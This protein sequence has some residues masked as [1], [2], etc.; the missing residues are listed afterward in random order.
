MRWMQFFTPV[1]S[2][3]ADEARRYIEAGSP[4]D[5][6]I[7]DVRQHVEYQAGH[8]AG[9]KLIPLG[10]LGDRL[11]EID[12]TLPTIVYC[13]IGGRS[14]VAAQMLAGKGFS[15]VFNLAGGFKAWNGDRA[16]GSQEQGL[17]T[18]DPGMSPEQCL[19]VAYS[20]EQG[21]RDFYLTMMEKASSDGVRDLFRKLADVEILH[22]NKL[23]EEYIHFVNPSASR[24]D[25]EKQIIPGISEGGMTTQEYLDH[26]NPDF[27]DPIDLCSMAMSIEAQAMDLYQR[28]ADRAVEPRTRKVLQ[29]IAIEERAHLNAL[30]ELINRL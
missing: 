15:K 17:S 20:M 14:R 5:M 9:A 29:K 4:A 25:F 22:Q 2:F 16:V 7:L 3:N 28:G 6:T 18:L 10:E 27:N 24:E 8:I 19:V 21:L 13:A 12:S 30:G 23:L 11:Q 26:F 1:E